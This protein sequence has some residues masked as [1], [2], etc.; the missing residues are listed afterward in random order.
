MFNVYHSLN[1]LT[2][3]EF[4]PLENTLNAEPYRL[5]SIV[6]IIIIVSTINVKKYSHH[7]KSSLYHISLRTV[8]KQSDIVENGQFFTDNSRTQLAAKYNKIRNTTTD[9]Y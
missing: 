6:V 7:L 5:V 3:F 9:T 1:I 2:F 4:I 8:L